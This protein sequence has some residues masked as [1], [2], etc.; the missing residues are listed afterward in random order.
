MVEYTS[1]SKIVLKDNVIRNLN[2]IIGKYTNLNVTIPMGSLFYTEW[3]VNAEDLPGNWLKQ[4]KFSEGE[5]AQYYA[6]DT[7]STYGN[8]ILP[9][10]YIDIEMR[11]GAENEKIMYGKLFRNVK[12]L[13]VHD[14]N[15]SNVFSDPENKSQPANIVFALSHDNSNLLMRAKYLN[16]LAKVELT[17]KPQGENSSG[18]KGEFVSS[19]TLRDYVDKNTK[20]VTDEKLKEV[21]EKTEGKN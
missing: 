19:A 20:S 21:T 13:A 17:I 5:E 14:G 8:S 2:D 16:R 3:L 11:I 15:G 9:G 1:I 10:S 6:V 12:V 4:I 7:A 18:E